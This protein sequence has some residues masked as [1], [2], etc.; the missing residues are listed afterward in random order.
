[1]EAAVD[2]VLGSLYDHTGDDE[3][4]P[5]DAASGEDVLADTVRLSRQSMGGRLLAAYALGSLAHGGFSPLVSDVDVA[6]V[7]AD[8]VLLSDYELLLG[9][10]EKVRSRGSPL[11]RRVS[12]FWGTPASLGGHTDGGRFPPLDRLCLLEHGRLLTGKDVRNCLPYP[13]HRDLVV[14]GAQF[15]LDALAEDVAAYAGQLELL[16]TAGVRWMT[17]IVLF[18]VRFLFTAETGREGTNDAA[19]HHYLAQPQAPGAALVAAALDWRT[20]PPPREHAITMLADG[21]ISLYGHYLADY[22]QRLEIYGE[23]AL[24]QAFRNWRSH[25]LDSS[26]LE[27]RVRSDST[28]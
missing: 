13:N 16:I 19:A 21:F 11:H 26:G 23:P 28:T 20:N 18:P 22:I 24:A 27:A 17:K 10:A 3:A 9:V 12:I 4:W 25:L 8:S 2:E 6:L 1:M 15:A 14:T 7:L 5:V